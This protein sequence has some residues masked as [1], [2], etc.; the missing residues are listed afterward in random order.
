GLLLHFHVRHTVFGE[1]ALL[2][3]DEQRRSVRQ[4]D[5]AELGSLHFG[6]CALRERAGGEIQPG[7]GEQRCR[8]TGRLQDLTAAKSIWGRMGGLRHLYRY[9]LQL[10]WPVRLV[11]P[12]R[13]RKEGRVPGRPRNGG[14]TIRMMGL[15]GRLQW[16]RHELFKLRAKPSA[17]QKSYSFQ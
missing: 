11:P 7:R 17:A 6:T 13:V 9:P 16:R 4:R 3:G 14:V 8:S 12:R 10:K 1:D 2:L 5:E 15:K